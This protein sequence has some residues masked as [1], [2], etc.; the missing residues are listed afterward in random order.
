V[1]RLIAALP[2]FVVLGVGATAS[3]AATPPGASTGGTTAVAPQTAT[4]HGKVNPH[5]APTAFYFR[6]GTTTGYGHRTTTTSAG[7]GTRARS[8]SAPLA[9]LRPNTTYHYRLVAFSTAGTRSG[10]DRAFKTK[11]IPTTSSILASPNPVAFGG[12]VSVAGSLTGP[13]VGGKLVALQSKPF[14]FTGAFQQVGNTV[15]TNPQ[16]GYSFVVPGFIT[17]QLRVVDRSKPSVTSQT[18]TESVALA[19]TIHARH[20]RKGSRRVRFYGRVRPARVGNAVLIQRKLRKRWK[21]IGLT[22]TRARNGT[23]SVF[24]KRLRLGHSGTF[25]VV[26]RTTGGDYVDGTSPEVRVHLRHRRR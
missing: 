24:S 14:P 13:S 11:Q 15:V 26:V 21:T 8:V 4:V 12:L 18:I 20:F 7:S 10:G 23:F 2:V 25:R 19:T 9:G 3:A 6:Y 22:L 5:G 17:A 1:Q 16:G